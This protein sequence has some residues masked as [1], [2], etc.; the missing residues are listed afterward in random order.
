MTHSETHRGM[1]I[2]GIILIIYAALVAT[3]EGEFWPFSIYP[4]FSQAGNPWTRA[5]VM[6]ITDRSDDEMWVRT[7]LQH[8]A[9]EPVP[10]FNYGVDQIDFSNFVSK[11]EDWTE[12]RIRAMH[13]MFG[14]ENIGEN[15]WMVAK[16]HGRMVG[17]DSVTVEIEPLILLTGDDAVLNPDYR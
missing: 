8:K 16:V 14:G 2:I 4:M 9:G 3:H 10:V 15:R 13:T 11:T 5:M 1:K 6:D 17:A 12:S 7:T